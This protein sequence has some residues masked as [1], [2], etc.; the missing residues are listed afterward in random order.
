MVINGRDVLRCSTA[1]SC[2]GNNCL[3]QTFLRHPFIRPAHDGVLD[4]YAGSNIRL[5]MQ[6]PHPKFAIAS[7]SLGSCTHHSLPTKISV[8]SALGYQGIEIFFPDFEAFVDEVKQGQ[9]ANLLPFS[10]PQSSTRDLERACAVALSTLCKSHNLTIPI[11]QPFRNFEN[12]ADQQ[13]LDDALDAAERWL[14]LMPYFDC[15]LL[16][17]CSNFIEGPHPIKSKATTMTEYLDAQ[18]DA[19]RLLGERASKHGTRIGYEPLS[20]GTV[21]DRWEYVWDV[22][23]RVDMPNVGVILDSFNTL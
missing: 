13:H 21:I 6:P 4:I 2:A 17:V 5:L 15:D 18:V 11:I 12:F 7:L 3:P 14:D 1:G 23:R 8:A 10:V 19:F 22:V 9:H 20:W 16:L